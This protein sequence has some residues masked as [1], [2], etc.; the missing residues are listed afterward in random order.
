M[1]LQYKRSF[2]VELNFFHI[3]YLRLLRCAFRGFIPSIGPVIFLPHFIMNTISLVEYVY[4][5][6]EDNGLLRPHR[7]WNMRPLCPGV[8]FFGHFWALRHRVSCIWKAIC[9]F[10]S[11]VIPHLKTSLFC[12]FKGRH[13]APRILPRRILFFQADVS[14]FFHSWRL[15]H[16][17]FSHIFVFSKAGASRLKIS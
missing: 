4:N 8:Y 14:R 12:I 3:L 11:L 16:K 5:G 15:V 10:V 1:Y 6:F 13:F 2:C 7:S 9:H 17:I